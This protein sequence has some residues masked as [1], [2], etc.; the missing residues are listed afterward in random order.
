MPYYLFTGDMEQPHPFHSRTQ[1]MPSCYTQKVVS[2]VDL[3]AKI[4]GV[5]MTCHAS[6]VNLELSPSCG[7]LNILMHQEPQVLETEKKK[8]AKLQTSTNLI[9]NNTN[10]TF[11]QISFHIS[12]PRLLRIQ[13]LHRVCE[14][15]G[16]SWEGKPWSTPGRNV[17]VVSLWVLGRKLVT[18]TVGWSCMNCHDVILT[19]HCDAR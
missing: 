11:H 18:Y 2:L 17:L 8:K 19:M 16:V 3:Q 12:G 9:K 4:L 10:N 5:R 1:G 7:L 14:I 6:E 13:G 15:S